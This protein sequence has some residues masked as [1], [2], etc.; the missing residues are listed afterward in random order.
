MHLFLETGIR[1]SVSM[2][3]QRFAATN[4]EGI[5]NF[6]PS[7]AFRYIIYWDANNF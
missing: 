4:N 2:I 5:V 1:D 3:N 6:Y 7:Q